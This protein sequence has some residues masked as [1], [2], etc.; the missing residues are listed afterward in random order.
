MTPPTNFRAHPLK[1]AALPHSDSHR[2][3]I[4][5]DGW[6]LSHIQSLWRGQASRV[7]T[8]SG[9]SS[10]TRAGVLAKRPR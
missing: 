2:L 6:A 3:I 9:G 10:A 4:V 5:L 7:S 1:P 8:S